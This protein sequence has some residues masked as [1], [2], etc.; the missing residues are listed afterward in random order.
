MNATTSIDKAGRLVVPKAMRDALHL[1]SGELL[2]VEQHDDTIVLRPHR[3]GGLVKRDGMWVITGEAGGISASGLI[4]EHREERI[5]D[6]IR[7]GAN[8]GDAE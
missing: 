6:L 4:D 3:R 8:P 2:D 7:L 5:Q 1:K